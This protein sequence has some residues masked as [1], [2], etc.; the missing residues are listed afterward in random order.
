MKPGEQCPRCGKV[1]AVVDVDV[2]QRICR[3]CY[4]E[5]KREVR[6]A[7]LAAAA[8]PVLHWQPLWRALGLPEVRA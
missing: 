1:P 5:R 3:P 2:R 6:I 7:A 8:P 4:S